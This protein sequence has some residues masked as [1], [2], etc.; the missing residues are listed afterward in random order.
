MKLYQCHAV[1]PLVEP[2]HTHVVR[3]YVTIAATWEEARKRVGEEVP[4]AVFV[5]TPIETTSPLLTGTTSMDERELADLRSACAWYEK[6]ARNAA[7]RSGYDS[8]DTTGD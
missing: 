2:A 3:T 8:F 1:L 5:T 7:A 6:Q 4:T